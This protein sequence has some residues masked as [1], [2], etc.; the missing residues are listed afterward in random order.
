MEPGGSAAITPRLNALTKLAA[1][2]GLT[3]RRAP[4]YPWGWEVLD[5]AKLVY[6]GT[7]DDLEEWCR[8]STRPRTE[9]QRPTTDTPRSNTEGSS[10]YRYA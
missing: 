4:N 9:S 3:V 5:G 2:K 8:K 7:M 10:D 1:D 6:R